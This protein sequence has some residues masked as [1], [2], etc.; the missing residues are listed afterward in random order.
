MLSTAFRDGH[1]H[2]EQAEVLIVLS[3]SL[4]LSSMTDTVKN[5]LF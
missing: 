1:S 3:G 4:R 2:I 5:H